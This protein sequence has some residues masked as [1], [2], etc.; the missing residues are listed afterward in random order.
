M[1]FSLSEEQAML[2]D[3]VEKFL[4]S[5][6][7]FDARQALVASPDGFSREHWA[8]YADLG[9]LAMLFPE[10]HGGF[11]GGAVETMLM[12]E[13]FGRGLVVEPFL[14]TVIIA[15]QL[16]SQHGNDAQR[17]QY[18]CGITEGRT[19]GT[20]AW[21]E[22]QARYDLTN[23]RTTAKADD[24][25]WVLNGNKAV[26]PHAASAD[27]MIVPARTSGESGDAHGITL[28]VLDAN[29]QGIE[30]R[31]YATVDGQRASQVSLNDVSVS[32]DAVLGK[33]E[34]GLAPLT[35]ALGQA[36]LAVAAEAVG[37]MDILLAKTL[38]YTKQRKQFGVP[39]SSFQALQHRMVD[40]LMMVEQS[41]S[42]LIH[43]VLQ[44][45]AGSE[46]AGEAIAAVKYYVGHHGRKLGE[47]AVQ[48]HGG[49]GV[50]NEL[51]VAHYF[52]RLI[53]IDTLFGNADFQLSTFASARS[54]N[55]LQAA[56]ERAA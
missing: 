27:F 22:S 14:S 32:A 21:V 16:L 23:V 42:L 34:Q 46:T 19:L 39:I 41:R 5:S 15:G 20:L 54:S 43:A 3:S 38:E 25:G 36:T 48:L 4:Q 1:D 51:D 50:T 35:H 17:E 44:V 28:F 10:Q 33:A 12:M 30:R 18:L 37:V 55:T 52:K 8:T 13:Q 2:K 45:Q 24:R 53:S 26:V 29:T 31:D 49:M 6:Y 7:D 40:M 11:N 47:E 9:W 56:D